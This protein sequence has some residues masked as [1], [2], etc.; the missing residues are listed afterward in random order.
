MLKIRMLFFVLFVLTTPALADDSVVIAGTGDS[1]ELLRVLAIDYQHLHSD[2]SITVPDSIGSSGGV[3]AAAQG[4]ADF[5]RIARPLKDKEK[6]HGLTYQLFAFSPVVFVANSSL[7]GVESL[8]QEQVLDVYSGKIMNWKELGGSDVP[9]LVTGR[10]KGDSS[11]SVLEKKLSGFNA[12]ERFV[13]RIL[14]S[15]PEAVEA[16]TQNA[17]SIGYLPLAMAQH[18]GVNI[19]LLDGKTPSIDA[20]LDGSYNLVSPFGLVWKEPLKEDARQ[21]LGYLGSERARKIMTEFGVV[22]AAL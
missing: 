15:T 7:K 17:G 13:G 6:V 10:E 11:R 8:T 22:P 1:Q 9:I 14:F 18:S 21:F 2:K 19:L 16:V 5:G 4:V 20:V 12:V 3:K